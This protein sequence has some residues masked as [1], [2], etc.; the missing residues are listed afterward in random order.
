[1]THEELR[2]LKT[3][4]SRQPC[5]W[6]NPGPFVVG[7]P[8][9]QGMRVAL[10]SEVARTH[11]ELVEQIMQAGLAYADTVDEDTSVVICNQPNPEQVLDDETFMTEV[12]RV[13]GGTDVEQ[14]TV[15]S[16][17]GAQYSLF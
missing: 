10:S 16:R 9:V 4:A 1:M 5:H 11:E 15:P 14:F 6:L 3:V 17:A 2:S 13:V 7:Q 12:R 8:L